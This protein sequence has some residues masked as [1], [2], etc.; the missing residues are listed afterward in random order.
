M[1]RLS[2]AAN[3]IHKEH[4]QTLRWM[5]KV[6][7][8]GFGVSTFGMDAYLK[9]HVTGFDTPSPTAHFSKF[10]DPSATDLQQHTAWLE[11]IRQNIWA[12]ISY[13]NDMIQ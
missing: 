6:I 10:M 11:D 3:P 13:E 7:N 2:Q 5:T 4:W 1:H 8:Y 9:K 12:R